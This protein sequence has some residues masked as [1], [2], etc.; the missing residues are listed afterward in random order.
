MHHLYCRLHELLNNKIVTETACEKLDQFTIKK[1]ALRWYDVPY[2]A[3]TSRQ[4][5]QFDSN[6]HLW[7]VRAEREEIGREHLSVVWRRREKMGFYKAVWKMRVAWW[8]LYLVV[9]ALAIRI[10]EAVFGT[11]STAVAG[12]MLEML[13]AWYCFVCL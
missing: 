9:V 8:I 3:F 4:D 13:I 10:K 6:M 7:N 2:Y 1:I 5:K 11:M 12:T